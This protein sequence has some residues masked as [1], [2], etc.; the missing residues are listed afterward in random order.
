MDFEDIWNH[1]EK[2]SLEKAAAA[3]DDVEDAAGILTLKFEPFI[4]HVQCR[5][6]A[7]A[8]SL[9]TLSLDCGYR[10]SGLT[11]GKAGKI[12]LAVRSTHG[13]EVP[14]SDT[15]GKPLVSRQYVE[16]VCRLANEKLAENEVKF[17]RFEKRFF[18]QFCSLPQ[19]NKENV[20]QPE[21]QEEL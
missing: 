7:A 4:L 6:Q 17:R 14:L 2:Q 1:I 12:V 3:S 5:D 8:K 10:N 18:Q 21:S 20:G 13:L 9:H 11:L 16:L 15:D 19:L